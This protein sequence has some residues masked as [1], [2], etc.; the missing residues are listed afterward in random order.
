ML[1]RRLRRFYLARETEAPRRGWS[2]MPR[3]IFST[4]TGHP[5]HQPRA[6]ARVFTKASLPE[7][8][9][10]HSPR[11]SFGSALISEG[12]SLAYPQ[13][14]LGHASIKLTVELYGE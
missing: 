4:R 5:Y 2:E 3:W 13:R 14:M 11:Q 12:E 10:P 8:F 7:H 1:T 9:R 6:F